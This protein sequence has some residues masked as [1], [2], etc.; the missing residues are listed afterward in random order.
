[1]MYCAH[2]NVDCSLRASAIS[3][4]STFEDSMLHA[5]NSTLP[6]SKEAYSVQI[7][8]RLDMHFLGGCRCSGFLSLRSRLKYLLP[9]LPTGL[10]F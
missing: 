2:Y 6:I 7:G 8:V 10:R 3:I 1:M 9:R 4:R 5:L